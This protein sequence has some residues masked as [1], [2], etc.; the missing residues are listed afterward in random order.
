MDRRIFHGDITP[1]EIGRAI[2]AHFDRGNYTAQQFVHQG[3]VIVQVASLQRPISG[4]QTALTVYL[5]PIEDGIAIQLGEQAWLGVA[6]SIGT[7]ILSIWK[8]PLNLLHRLDDIAQ[9]VESLQLS[10]QI[11]RIIENVAR[12]KGATFE[13][14]ERLRRME[15]EYCG[16]ANPVGEPSCIACGAPLGKIQPTTCPNCGF[17]VRQG[18]KTCPNCKHPLHQ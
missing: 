13:L 14:S 17:I 10:E 2:V 4:G 15:C 1:A 11:W 16:T 9:D 18:E 3:K 12:M 7:T 6:A 5:E 8:N